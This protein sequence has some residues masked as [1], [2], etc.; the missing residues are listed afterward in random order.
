MRSIL[1]LF[2]ALA[3]FIEYFGQDHADLL[4]KD[5]M[6][7][8]SEFLASHEK[9]QL[10]EITNS[11]V[12]VSN[13]WVALFE[14]DTINKY[15]RSKYYINGISYQI[16]AQEV[17]DSVRSWYFGVIK[18]DNEI[19]YTCRFGNIKSSLY[20]PVKGN[21]K[22]NFYSNKLPRGKRETILEPFGEASCMSEEQLSL[23]SKFSSGD[24]KFGYTYHFFNSDD[25]LSIYYCT[26]LNP[27]KDI[28]GEI[29]LKGEKYKIT[30][31]DKG[32]K[33]YL[34][35]MNSHNVPFAT[36]VLTKAKVDYQFI[37]T[38]NCVELLKGKIHTINESEAEFIFKKL[39]FPAT[40]YGSSGY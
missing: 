20:S 21:L 25:S 26:S 24:N 7:K 16:V 34:F 30:G 22:F 15:C 39:N 35:L 12:Y 23:M 38:K 37:Y 32:N 36:I 14:Y 29:M 27:E 13:G 28:Q 33:T 6:E 31:T 2:F 3:F 8:E 40:S 9:I 19:L 1:I 17:S 18:K 10:K 4:P 11:A 5:Y